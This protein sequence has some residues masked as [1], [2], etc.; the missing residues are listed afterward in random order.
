MI[1]LCDFNSLQA[2]ITCIFLLLF[3]SLS[4]IYYLNS[5][6]FAFL[7]DLRVFLHLYFDCFL[8]RYIEHS[9]FNLNLI[10]L[11]ASWVILLRPIHMINNHQR[12]HLSYLWGNIFSILA[13]LISS[14]ILC[15]SVFFCSLFF[16][17]SLRIRYSLSWFLLCSCS[18]D[19]FF[20]TL[21]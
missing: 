8:R 7:V 16:N 9:H 11:L 4:F 13:S 12:L 21:S 1:L 3:D 2:A 5:I 10:L 19:W 17:F 14:C 20:F 6:F 15:F 18:F